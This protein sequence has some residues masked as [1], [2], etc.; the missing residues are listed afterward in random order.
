MPDC[1]IARLPGSQV[2]MPGT[3]PEPANGHEGHIDTREF[4]VLDC[5]WLE[6]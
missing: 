4:L 2:T 3:L 1:Q 6:A 5:P